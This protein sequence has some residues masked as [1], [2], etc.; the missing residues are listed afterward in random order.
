MQCLSI[1]RLSEAKGKKVIGSNDCDL[2]IH[3][4][5]RFRSKLE[6]HSKKADNFGTFPTRIDDVYEAAK[7]VIADEDCQLIAL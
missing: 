3:Q 7:I 4:Y 1:L 2:E 6:S 5:K